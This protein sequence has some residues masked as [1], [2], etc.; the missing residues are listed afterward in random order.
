MALEIAPWLKINPLKLHSWVWLNP[1]FYKIYFLQVENTRVV[2]VGN[3]L[4]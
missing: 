2:H 1:C 4:Y 3:G